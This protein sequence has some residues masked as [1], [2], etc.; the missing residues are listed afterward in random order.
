VCACFVSHS[1]ELIFF[2]AAFI[3]SE[4]H[5]HA[6]P[7][8]H[9]DAK[10]GQ[11]CQTLSIGDLATCNCSGEYWTLITLGVEKSEWVRQ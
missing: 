5:E 2:R 4:G 1:V 11:C 6:E 8:T 3:E 10:M 7:H 9:T